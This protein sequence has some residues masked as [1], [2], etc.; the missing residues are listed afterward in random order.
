M[1]ILKDTLR[2]CDVYKSRAFRHSTHC[3]L[4]S[5]TV[6]TAT[7]L[8]LNILKRKHTLI[9]RHLCLNA[10]QRWLPAIFLDRAEKVT[11]EFPRFLHGHETT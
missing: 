5:P 2:R 4:V 8:P 9:G 11:D 1:Q 3:P 6:R 7:G 10:L